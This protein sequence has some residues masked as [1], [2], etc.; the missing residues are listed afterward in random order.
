[1][2]QP[3]QADTL[4]NIPSVPPMLGLDTSTT[5]ISNLP[6]SPQGSPNFNSMY[7]GPTTPLPGAATPQMGPQEPMAANEAFGGM[8]G[9]TAF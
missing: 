2:H 9:G 6:T 5:S 4:G 3:S 1:M 8:F 7:Q